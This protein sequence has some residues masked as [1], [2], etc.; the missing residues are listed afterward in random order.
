MK[1]TSWLRPRPLIWLY[2]NF[3]VQ[4]QWPCNAKVTK[5]PLSCVCVCVFVWVWAGSCVSAW[6]CHHSSLI[7]AMIS[8]PQLSAY[9]HTQTQNNVRKQDIV[10]LP[11]SPSVSLLSS[12]ASRQL[13]LTESCRW[14]Q[15]ASLLILRGLT[16]LFLSRATQCDG[17][18]FTVK[19]CRAGRPTN[20][21]SMSAGG[22]AAGCDTRSCDCMMSAAFT[23]FLAL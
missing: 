15:Q 1:I 13:K 21:S 11:V 3:S 6:Q 18:G 8:Q 20:K 7:L 19:V 5:N 17:R 23:T 10:S 4:F 12:D 9:A 2:F 14:C 16:F 22:A